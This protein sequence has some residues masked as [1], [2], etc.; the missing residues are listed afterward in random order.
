ME[1]GMQNKETNDR[2]PL[3]IGVDL[4]GTQIRTAVLHGS[5]LLSRVGILTG[6]NP[7]PDHIIPRIYSAI[8]EALHQAGI[9]IQQ[10]AGIGIAAPVPLDY[11]TGIIYAPP[12]LPQRQDSGRSKRNSSRTW[13]YDD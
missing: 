9:T 2:L 8:D 13:P 11:K 6:E 1:R 10:I 5:T 7:M 4:G 3:V 12:N